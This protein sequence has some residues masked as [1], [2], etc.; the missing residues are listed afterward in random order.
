MLIPSGQL[1]KLRIVAFRKPEMLPQHIFGQMEVLIN[2]E[3][4]TK[5]YSIEYN[6]ETGEGKNAKSPKFTKVGPQSMEFRFLFDRTGVFP[7][8][9]PLPGGVSADIV[10]FKQLTYEFRGKEHKPPYLRLFWGTLIFP[11]VLKSMSIEYKLFSPDGTPRRAVI[12]GNFQKFEDDSLLGKIANLLSPD[13]T[14]YYVV[15]AGDTLPL[16]T[17]NIYGDAKYYLEI[18][19]LNQLVNFKDLTPGQ[20][21]IFPPLE[22]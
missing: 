20:Q 1:G 3:G 16:L 22:K 9:P 21:L 4:Y 15:K 7:T 6:E 2:P 13:L 11:C 18:A 17:K 10:L 14:H 8:S 12:T 5:E 19:R